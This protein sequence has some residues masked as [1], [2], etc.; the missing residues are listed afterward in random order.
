MFHQI[1]EDILMVRSVLAAQSQAASSA[2][3]IWVGIASLVVSL[4]ALVGLGFSLHQTNKSLAASRAA[5]RTTEELAKIQS[6][7]YVQV[8][9]LSIAKDGDLL[10]SCQN[11]GE[12]PSPFF[13]V[14]A[15]AVRAKDGEIQHTLKLDMGSLDMKSWVAL[16]VREAWP[17]K[18]KLSGGISDYD[19]FKN[20]TLGVGENL[21][22]RGRV[23]YQDIFGTFFMT[24]FAFYA[25]NETS[26]RKF[27]QP[28][29]VLAAYKLLTQA[30]ANGFLG[31]NP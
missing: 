14:G 27:L 21:L 2:A 10:V 22:V 25:N 8:N 12:T 18:I 31:Q 6:R 26:G 7:A 15:T 13:A 4:G 3:A 5:A 19:A 17:A 30:E 23:V 29:G 16:G 28:F 1:F 11:A 9:M 20:G 24:E